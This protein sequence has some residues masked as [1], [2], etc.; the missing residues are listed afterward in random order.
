MKSNAQMRHKGQDEA[1][2]P[3]PVQFELLTGASSS[4]TDLSPPQY[5]GGFA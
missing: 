5:D 4:Q 3:L 1:P 2:Q